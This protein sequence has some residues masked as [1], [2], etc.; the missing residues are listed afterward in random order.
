MREIRYTRQPLG[1]VG[2]ARIPTFLK[3]VETTTLHQPGILE[4][5]ARKPL[6]KNYIKKLLRPLLPLINVIITVAYK[7]INY[8]FDGLIRHLFIDGYIKRTIGYW[9]RRYVK[10]GDTILEIGVGGTRLWRYLDLNYC[11]YYGFDIYDISALAGDKNLK[12]FV[13]SASD[14]PLPNSSID[15]IVSTEVFEH[16][17]DFLK[18]L[19]EIH[20]VCKKNA[21]LIVSIPNNYV[22]KYKIK[23]P[24]P[25]HVNNWRYDEFINILHP[26]FDL[27]EGRMNGWWIPV[28]KKSRYSLQLPISHPE[29]YYNS[30]FFYIFKCRK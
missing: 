28:F 8:N 24:H 27:I 20:R 9:L 2:I 3:I 17:K 10:K 30:N 18:T 21:L 1:Y 29:E 23:G 13:A 11:Y 25:E 12:L 5:F 26:Y 6:L 15:I 14:I 19:K 22:H 16:I 4:W 7:T